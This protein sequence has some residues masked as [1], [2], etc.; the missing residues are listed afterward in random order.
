[1][2]LGRGIL[3]K[4]RNMNFDSVTAVLVK[5]AAII[6]RVMPW[7]YAY[8]S[9]LRATWG[10]HSYFRTTGMLRSA[11]LG[12]PV[13]VDGAPLPLMTYGIID[14]L[15]H[16]LTNDLRVFEFGSGSSTLFFAERA[17]HV[18]SVEHDPS[19]IERLSG[20]APANVELIHRPNDADA[21]YC[22][23]ID[24]AG[25]AFDVVLID[26]RDRFN[27][28]RRA[29]ARVGTAGVIIFD[30]SQSDRYSPALDIGTDA[31]FRRLDFPGL[32]PTGVRESTTTLFYRA[33]NCLGI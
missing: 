7:P 27:C 4:G 28:M 32:R 11:A 5:L 29:V 24:D 14:V 18:T 19:W 22:R 13:T 17:R 33:D 16:R 21:T 20:L 31:G 9:A 25:E 6:R 10:R 2:E 8:L 12:R 3:G 23:A 26:G 30:D 15:Q 1:M